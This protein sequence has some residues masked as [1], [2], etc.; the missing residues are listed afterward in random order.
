MATV[1][2]KRDNIK[3]KVPAGTTMRKVATKTGASL[4]FGCRVGDCGSCVAT[5]ESGMEHLS[6]PN[7]KER[8]I[9]T[10]IEGD[11]SVQRLMCQVDVINDAGEIVIL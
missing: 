4:E 5:V 7:D 10:I 9:M 11:L 1:L 6:V 2:L 3:V 8:H